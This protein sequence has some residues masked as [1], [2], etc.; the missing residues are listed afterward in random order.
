MSKV[1]KSP[2]KYVQGQNIL[3]EFD[4]YL[5]GMGKR[6]LILVGPHVN[7]FVRPLLDRCFAGKDYDVAFRGSRANR[8]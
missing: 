8:C 5:Q 4:A 1:L 3:R 2:G 6:P 7:T